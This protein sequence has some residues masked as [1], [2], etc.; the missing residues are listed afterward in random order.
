MRHAFPLVTT[1]LLCSG[2][3]G[4]IT[5]RPPTKVG[6]ALEYPVLG[7]SS[8]AG[9]VFAAASPAIEEIKQYEFRKTAAGTFRTTMTVRRAGGTGDVIVTGTLNASVP[10]A[11]TWLEDTASLANINTLGGYSGSFTPDLLVFVFDSGMSPPAP[12]YSVRA[13]TAV[14]FP[15]S[16][17][18]GTLAGFVDSKV[19]VRDGKTYFAHVAGP[20]LRAVELDPSVATFNA[21][22]DPRIGA[23]FVLAA[24]EGFS[25]HSPEL[26]PDNGNHAR[27]LIL[28]ANSGPNGSARPWFNSTVRA[29]VD[30]T[31]KSWQFQTGPGDAT[32][33]ANPG[34]LGGSMFYAQAPPASAYGVPKLL[35]LVCSSGD[36]VVGA[37][38]GT[39]RLSAWLPYQ[40]LNNA[41]VTLLLGTPIMDVTVPGF[42]GK[43]AVGSFFALPPQSWA[44]NDT[45]KDWTVL[46][47]AGLT[48]GVL[49]AQTLVFDA[50]G[51]VA[52]DTWYFG[53]TAPLEIL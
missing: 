25:P 36:A 11:W 32:W 4:Q 41:A 6:V 3:A 28:A 47:P 7:P 52:G 14:P 30:N 15:P 40:E 48:P 16:K 26:L 34:A 33:L 19:Y 31:E 24:F 53:N 51:S 45:A 29:G 2:L 5:G 39:L 27:A 8:A 46:V 17:P 9:S 1:A 13:S 50:A 18:I 22:T 35:R 44:A 49:W 20:D 12:H 37:T 21:G 42:R 10:G 43:L 38:G 23:S